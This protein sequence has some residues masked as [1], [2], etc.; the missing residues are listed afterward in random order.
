VNLSGVRRKATT[1][2]SS[3]AASSTPATSANVTPVPSS[4]AIE[5]VDRPNAATPRVGP[6]WRDTNSQNSPT[7]TSGSNI[8]SDTLPVLHGFGCTAW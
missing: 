3:S 5:A 6:D 8:T 1:S 4:G 7:T 2:C